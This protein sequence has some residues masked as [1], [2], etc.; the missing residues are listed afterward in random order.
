MIYLDHNAT[1]P[2]R[3][4]AVEAM[5]EACAV[6]GNASSVHGAG[7][8]ARRM[9]ENARESV[10]ALVG[11]RPADVIFTSGGSEANNMALLGC[12]RSRIITT[13]IEHDSVLAAAGSDALR[14]PVGKDGTVDVE[15]VRAL[16][17]EDAG[18]AVVSVMLVNNETG[19]I[20]PVRAI[21]EMV[22]EVGGLMHVDAIQ[23]VGKMP[24]NIGQL[25]ADML[26]VSGHKF[27]APAG[28]G[29]LVTRP[30][31]ILAP[32]IVGGGQERRQR[33]GTENISC[34]NAMGVVS[35]VVSEEMDWV[36]QA[37][38]QRDALESA[39][40]SS[41][42]DVVIF[43]SDSD[44]LGTTCCFGVAGMEAEKLLMALDLSGYAV[45]SGS[46][47]SSGKVTPSHVLTAMGIEPDLAR[48]ALR[49]SFG[50]N[51]GP[52]DGAGFYDAWRQV[53][54]RMAPSVAT[55]A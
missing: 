46:A 17:G 16:L 10:A 6:V 23:A 39:L 2:V 5:T 51:S 40:L 18:D 41:G 32:R 3:Q 15:A 22:R 29:A 55:A 48:S 27:G 26:S 45:S 36:D 53:M 34:I 30:G 28:V 1:T 4:E 11:A 25:G 14:I 31:L 35:R 19:V 21:A 8:S 9:I 7:R 43:G 47:C 20:Q 13:E 52:D 37:R 33:A 44:R 54:G 42:Y 24:V 38:F 49:V 50:W 12:A